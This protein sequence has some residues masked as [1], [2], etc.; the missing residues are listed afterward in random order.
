M[1]AALC[2]HIDAQLRAVHLP[3]ALARYRALAQELAVAQGALRLLDGALAAELDSREL[4]RYQKNLRAARFP[5][6]KELGSFDFTAMTECG[7]RG[8]RAASPVH[9]Q[10]PLPRL[11]A[12]QEVRLRFGQLE[13]LR[14]V[15]RI[16]TGRLPEQQPY[17]G[18]AEADPR[19][20][21]PGRRR[22]GA[23]DRAH[24]VGEPL[25]D[26]ADLAAVLARLADRAAPGSRPWRL[27]RSRPC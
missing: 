12:G 20:L 18:L 19:A 17:V 1:A 8:R 5:V 22:D 25:R 6:V 15:A 11:G 23:V 21:R 13:D 4:H 2:G 26:Q 27:R 3:G 9:E 10:Q 16:L 7:P 14:A 24:Q